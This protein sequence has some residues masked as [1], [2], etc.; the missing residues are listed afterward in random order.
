MR[1]DEKREFEDSERFRVKK[2][3]LVVHDVPIHTIDALHMGA[4]DNLLT[5][6][7]YVTRLV[8]A[9]R[10][11]EYEDEHTMFKAH[12]MLSDNAEQLRTLLDETA[13]EATRRDTLHE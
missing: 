2:A 6:E 1:N 9:Q 13:E 11:R 5:V 4:E 7:D 8:Y 3:T 12:E 10:L